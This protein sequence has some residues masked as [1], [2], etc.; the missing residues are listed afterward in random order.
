MANQDMTTLRRLLTQEK[1][2]I[3][4]NTR[5]NRNTMGH[6]WPSF[7]SCEIQAWTEFNIDT[8]NESYTHV[9]D[10][11]VPT[12]RLAGAPDAS[13]VLDGIEITNPDDVLRLIGWNDRILQPTL[14]L[15]KEHL[16]LQPGVRLQHQVTP[17]EGGRAVRIP[18][19]GN[20][21]VH[22]LVG[23]DDF[24]LPHLVI[25][26]GRPSTKFQGRQLVARPENATPAQTWPLRQLANLCQLAGTRYGYIVTDQD[27]VVCC[28]HRTERGGDQSRCRLRTRPGLPTRFRPV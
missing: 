25:G 6:N 8:L 22:H 24:P 26:L 17:P 18:G 20:V 21:R 1:P 27:L 15:A 13:A 9:L 2:F 12:A 5:A 3:P 4:C 7:R 19:G 28:F 14:A 23:I 11:E 10:L 16:E